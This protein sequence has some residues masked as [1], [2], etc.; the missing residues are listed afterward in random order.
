M[1]RSD[2]MFIKAIAPDYRLATGEST[3]IINQEHK[4]LFGA[5]CTQN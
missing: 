3:C 4:Q 5:M 1:E 2:S